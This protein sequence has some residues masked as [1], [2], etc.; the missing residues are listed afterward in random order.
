MNVLISLLAFAVAIFILVGIHEFGHYIVAKKFG[1]KVLKFSIGFGKEIFSFQG[2]ETRFSLSL[3]PL[4]GYVK[5]LD[6]RE[7]EVKKEE[8][9][10]EFTNLNVYKRFLIVFAGPAINLILAVFLY[11]IIDM[12]GTTALNPVIGSVTQN[13]ISA[14]AG[15]KTNDEIIAVNSKPTKTA[16][17]VMEQILNNSLNESLSIQ[18]IDKDNIQKNIIL[19][20]PEQLLDNPKTSLNKKL[21]FSFLRPILKPIINTI[22]DNSPASLAGLQHSDL[23]L[24]TNNVAINSWQQWVKIIKKNALKPLNLVV[25]RN[26]QTITLLVVPNKKAIIGV[27]PLVQ[28]DLYQQYFSLDKKNFLEAT[29]NAIDKTYKQALLTVQLIGRIVIGNASVENISGPVKIASI[30][31]QTIQI[32]FLTFLGFLAVLSVSLGTLNLLPIHP[33]D[34]GHLFSYIIEII[35]GSE[36]SESFILNSQKIG[37]IIIFSLMSIAVYNDALYLFL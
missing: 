24:K 4:G 12:V 6:K 15:L 10:R 29:S 36:P 1:V 5:M 9:H 37:F 28:T 19:K 22:R 3:I 25:K 18:V 31:G 32:N 34:G 16:L 26:N 14:V 20:L 8:L 35:K 2:K 27:T 30:A 23:I 7:G 17:A 21:G 11:T 13:S 33:L